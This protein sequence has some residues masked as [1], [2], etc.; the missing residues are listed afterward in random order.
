MKRLILTIFATAS[1]V[2]TASGQTILKDFQP[3][4]DSLD[5]LIKENRD[6]KGK[7]RIKNIMKRGKT[8]DF[9]FTESLGDY[10]WREGEP[11]W[12][13]RQLKKLFPDKYRAFP[14]LS[15]LPKAIP[16]R[17]PPLRRMSSSAFSARAGSSRSIRRYR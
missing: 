11:E 7:L 17:L 13:R 4:C 8:L 5:V 3:V 9:Y 6:V 2:L 15:T 10:P 12:F 16:L 14:M 1:L